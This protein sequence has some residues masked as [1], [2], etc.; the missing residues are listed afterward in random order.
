MYVCIN[1]SH[2]IDPIFVLRDVCLIILLS[3]LGCF[4]WKLL[5]WAS[6]VSLLPLEPYRKIRASVMASSYL[7]YICVVTSNSVIIWKGGG[8]FE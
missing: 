6:P 3:E 5:M 1:A 7:N 4:M 2:V 8:R